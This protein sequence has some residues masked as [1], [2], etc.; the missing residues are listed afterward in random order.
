MRT[1]LCAVLLAGLLAGC[2]KPKPPSEPVAWLSNQAI[3][4]ALV[5]T[6]FVDK[7]SAQVG[8]GFHVRLA[9]RNIGEEPIPVYA[10]S[11]APMIVTVWRYVGAVGWERVREYP[12]SVIRRHMPWVLKPGDAG[13]TTWTCPWSPIGPRRKCSSCPP[14]SMA[15]RTC[16]RPSWCSRDPRAPR[17][18]RCRKEH[19]AAR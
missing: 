18:A 4:G 7:P 9:V 17:P 3:G 6:V 19:L 5:E 12:E 2:A 1:I 11:T 13:N 10:T 14:S 15:G 16:S 8:Q